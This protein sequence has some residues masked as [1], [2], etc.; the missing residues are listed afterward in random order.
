MS[1]CV[2]PNSVDLMARKKVEIDT[3]KLL[4]ALDARHEELLR[5]LEDLNLQIE[6]ALSQLRVGDAEMASA[7]AVVAETDQP[8]VQPAKPANSK[9]KKSARPSPV[10]K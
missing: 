10:G 4:H 6:L 5:D 7:P 8:R 3:S 9:A 1:D 2:T